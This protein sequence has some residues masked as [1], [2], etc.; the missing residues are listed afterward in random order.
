MRVRQFVDEGLGNSAHL[1]ISERDRV[2]GLVD[3][4]RDADRYLEA[5]RAEGVSITHVLETHLHNDFVSGSRE[6]AAATGATVGASAAGE[7]RYPH[8]PLRDGDRLPLGSLE[9]EV[10][11]TPGHTPEHICFL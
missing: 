7:L 8:R 1:L 6:L 3:P 9:I 10:M 11:A 2:A 4:L 5:A